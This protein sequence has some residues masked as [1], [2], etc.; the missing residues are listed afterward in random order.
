MNNN[1][2]MIFEGNN[3]EVFELNGQVLFNPKHVAEILDIVDVKSSIRDF[4]KKQVVKVKNSDVHSMHFRKLNN[5]GENFLTESGVYKLV[6]KS[7]KPEAERF[8]DWVTDEVLPSIR[9]HGAYMTNDVIERTLTDP[10]YLIQLATALKEER[11]ARLLAEQKIEEQKPLVDFANQVSD[12]TS[13]IDMNQMAKL[14]K[15]ENIPIGRNRLFEILRQKEILRNNNEPYQRY[16]ESGYF[17]IKENTYDTPYG[18]KTY[19]KTYITGKGQIWITEKLRKELG[20]V[21]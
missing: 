5:A 13:L 14:L 18:T 4:S 19:V 1:N 21:A 8:S 10:D 2:L 3:V 16:I 6:F 20:E 7:R 11:Q 9:K 15:D 12:T 17:K